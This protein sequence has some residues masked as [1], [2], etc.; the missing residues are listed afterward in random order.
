[1]KAC[2]GG[3]KHP[4]C[5]SYSEVVKSVKKRDLKPSNRRPL[6]R[7]ICELRP[8]SSL[9]TSLAPNVDLVVVTARAT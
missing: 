2:I 4:L 3:Q 1:M 9:G 7:V 6:G 5:R 8:A